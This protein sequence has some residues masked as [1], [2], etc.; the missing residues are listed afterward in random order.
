MKAT[1]I[2]LAAGHLSLVSRPREIADL[3]MAAAG[4]A[5]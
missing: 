4:R 5:P 2:E 3:I 1:T